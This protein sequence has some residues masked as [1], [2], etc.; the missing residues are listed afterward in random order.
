MAHLSRAV[1]GRLADLWSA[2]LFIERPAYDP[3][4]VAIPQTRDYEIPSNGRPSYRDFCPPADMRDIHISIGL[5][6]G[7][8]PS[9]VNVVMGFLNQEHRNRL[10]NTL[11]VA[12]CPESKDKYPEVAAI[13]APHV[14]Q[15]LRLSY[16]G[17]VVGGHRRAVRVF[18]SSDFPAITNTVG[19]KGHSVS[20]PCPCCLGMKC[21]TEAHSLLDEAFGTLQD[22]GCINPPRTAAHLR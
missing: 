14:A 9:S 11:L 10:G 15:L 17:V 12:V 13:L 21:P 19:H 16:S 20:I 7:G 18:V 3:Q 22:L 6:R 1:E 8:D 4:G 2:G 5:D